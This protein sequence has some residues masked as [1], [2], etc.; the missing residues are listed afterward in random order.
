MMMMMMRNFELN[1]N[2]FYRSTVLVYCIFYI[3]QIDII[4]N[5]VGFYCFLCFQFTTN[6]KRS[7]NMI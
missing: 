1:E 6:D 4:N 5:G 2:L 3:R 7:N